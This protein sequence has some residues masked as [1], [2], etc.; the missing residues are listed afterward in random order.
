MCSRLSHH[1]GHILTN[2]TPTSSRVLRNLSQLAIAN[3][4]IFLSGLFIATVDLDCLYSE[5]VMIGNWLMFEIL[6]DSS[7]KYLSWES[8]EMQL[9]FSY[10]GFDILRRLF[11]L[12]ENVYS[13]LT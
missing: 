2:L 3:E 7:M 6:L 1:L 8:E 9:G 5:V 11:S 12:M 10:L 4:S 13:S